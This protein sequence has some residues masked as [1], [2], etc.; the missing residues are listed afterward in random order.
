MLTLIIDPTKLVDIPCMQHEIEA[1]VAHSK[2]SPP[3]N[4]EEPVFVARDPERQFKKHDK[5]SIPI[6]DVTWK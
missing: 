6:D 1:I 2:A 4:P 3:A 5:K